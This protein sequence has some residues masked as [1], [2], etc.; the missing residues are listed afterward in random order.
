MHHVLLPSGLL[1]RSSQHT[2]ASFPLSEGKDSTVLL[3]LLRVAVQGLTG[4]HAAQE[5]QGR[6]KDLSV[7]RSSLSLPSV[8]VFV[9]VYISA[10][11]HQYD[12]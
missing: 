2:A 8:S 12:L 6:V 7:L 10:F 1:F 11:V 4:A 5:G 9:S 3:H